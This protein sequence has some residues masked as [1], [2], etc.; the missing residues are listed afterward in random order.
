[1][2]DHAAALRVGLDARV[3][4][5]SVGGVQQVLI[6]LAHGLSGLDDGDE[7][8]LFL[9]HDDADAWLR[10]Y[11]GGPC[12]TLSAGTRRSRDNAV[13]R[14][15]RDQPAVRH[16]YE[17][18]RR[19]RRGQQTVTPGSDG[20]I[21]RAG[22]DVMHFVRQ[23]AFVTAVPSIYQPHDLLHLWIPELFDEDT[24]RARETQYRTF[25]AQAELVV[26]M[27]EWGRQDLAARYG[28]SPAKLAVIPWAPVLDAYAR[29]GRPE[30]AALRAR[31]RLPER[32]LL[33]PAQTWPHKNHLG[34]LAALDSLRHAGQEIPLVLTG[35]ST[36]HEREVRSAI[37]RLGLDRLVHVLGFV[38]PGELLALYE[39]CDAVVIPSRFEGW[40]MPVVEAMRA[41][42]PV[43]CSAV[44][45]LPDIVG[46]AALLFDP[47]DPADIAAAVRRLWDDPQ[48]RATLAERGRRRVA[49][50]TW[51][52]VAR[53][54]RAHYRRLASRPLTDEDE[55]L[56]S[57]PSFA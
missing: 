54:F 8:Y 41:G 33:Y 51:D 17:Q 36:E 32:F 31:H 24:R 22:V 35:S 49:G 16:R 20:T 10:P 21:E 37:E 19:R 13:V 44:T 3:R 2:A 26:A 39:L 9:V 5:P 12:R 43:A 48:L 25:C 47:D 1:V 40:G 11:L 42:A 34:L 14:W 38:D 18:L 46:D 28:L 55:Q 29:H 4:H 56:L 7:E 23:E 52:G 50:L 53:R 45:C 30:G 6:G 57:E 27:T 15:L